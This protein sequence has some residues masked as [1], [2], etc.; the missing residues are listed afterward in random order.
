[1]PAMGAEVFD[2]LHVKYAP[3]PLLKRVLAYA[4]D[5]AIVTAG[6]YFCSLL[7]LMIGG[8]SFA[9]IIGVH[10][11][12]YN[13]IATVLQV[14]GLVVVLAALMHGYFVYHEHKSGS[15]PGKRLF[16]LRVVS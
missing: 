7:L 4:T 5:L 1:P 2:G 10:K 8:I 6:I 12:G 3:A 14:A 16:G 13:K 9:V 15:T 11:G